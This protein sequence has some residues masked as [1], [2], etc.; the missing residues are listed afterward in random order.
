M[1]REAMIA[2]GASLPEAYSKWAAVALAGLCPER[3]AGNL[4]PFD[5]LTSGNPDAFGDEII[6][7]FSLPAPPRPSLEFERYEQ[8]LDVVRGSL[9]D[10]DLIVYERLV[11]LRFGGS[12]EALQDLEAVLSEITIEEDRLEAL[13]VLADRTVPDRVPF[14]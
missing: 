8:N 1:F 5:A 2:D 7:Q 4:A 14:R 12:E 10:G 9:S 3:Q 11:A 6:G 13:L